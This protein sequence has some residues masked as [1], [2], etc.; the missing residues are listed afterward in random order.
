MMRGKI[1]FLISFLIIHVSLATAYYHHTS[2]INWRDYSQETFDQAVSEDK[3]VFMLVTAI[4]CHWCHVYRDQSLHTPEV[5]EYLNE[6]FIPVFVDADKRQDLTRQYMAGGWPTTVIFAPNGA[7]INSFSGH[8]EKDDLLA[9]LEKI[10]VYTQFY[11]IE[12]ESGRAEKKT[13]VSLASDKTLEKLVESFQKDIVSEFDSEYGGFG[14]TG[15]PF[16][17]NPKFP[18]GVTHDY[19][20]DLYE[21]TGDDVWLN[22]TLITLDNIASGG[23]DPVQGGIFR[24][25]YDPLEG[26]FFRYS[27]RRDWARPHYEKMLYGNARLIRAYLHAYQLTGR[28]D[29]QDVAVKSLHYVEKNLYDRESGGFYGSQDADEEYY[30]LSIEERRAYGPPRIDY[31][32]YSEWNAEMINTFFYATKVLG[33]ERYAQEAKKSL[34]FFMKNM[35]SKQGVLHYFDHEK[36]KGVLNGQL[37]DNAWMMLALVEGFKYTGNKDYLSSAEE[38]ASYSFRALHDPVGGGF[39]ERNSTDKELYLEGEL[40]LE[41]KPYSANGVMAYALTLLYNATGKPAY[42]KLAHETI[43]VFTREKGGFFDDRIYFARATMNLLDADLESL[44]NRE[45]NLTPQTS[46]SHKPFIILLLLSFI[47]GVLSFMSPCTLPVLTAYFSYTV[48]TEKR[49]L[50]VMTLAFFIGLASVFTLLGMTATYFGS[51]LNEYRGQVTRVGGLII[52]IFGVMIF[53]GRGFSGLKLSSKTNSGFLGTIVF[54]MLFGVGWSACIGPILASV[55]IIAA[56]SEGAYTG[57]MLLF[58]YAL[59]LVF[60]LLLVSLTF[61]NLDEKNI[62]WRIMRGRL[63]KIILFK[64]NFYLHTTTMVSGVLIILLGLLMWFG[65]LYSLNSIVPA[66]FQEPLYVVEQF[67]VDVV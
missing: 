31:T 24:G 30:L 41:S 25:I 42:L 18:Q 50:V 46:I 52:T 35:V 47:A 22:I 38:L 8:L 34:D 7:K 64:R 1:L 37:M 13:N 2:Q 26:G 40:F 28:K 33:D 62:V 53:F 60:P 3:P 23:D 43:S 67:I 59:G 21:E 16:Y 65:L 51:L 5:T 27:I 10:A 4:W 55:F 17:S 61:E 45:F 48:R 54:G 29:Y 14:N 11:T 56:S 6:N 36:E 44:T 57:G 15:S 12:K 32:K 63:V 49:K 20:L 19:M 9:H 66:S 58:T 39:Y